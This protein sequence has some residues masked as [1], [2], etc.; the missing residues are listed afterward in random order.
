MVSST[1]SALAQYIPEARSVWLHA[2][3]QPWDAAESFTVDSVA[4]LVEVARANHG[5]H[6]DP[7]SAERYLQGNGPAPHIAYFRPYPGTQR[8]TETNRR[9]QR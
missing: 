8:V 5:Q 9:R 6:L 7:T 2:H 1:Y 3:E 4:E